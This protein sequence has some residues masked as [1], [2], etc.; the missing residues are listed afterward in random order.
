VKGLAIAMLVVASLSGCTQDVDPV[1]PNPAESP[2]PPAQSTPPTSSPAE[3][4]SPSSLLEGAPEALAR[5]Y[6]AF[7][8]GVS[9]QIGVARADGSDLR[10]LTDNEFPINPAWSP[11][12]DW[13][14]YRVEAVDNVFDASRYG[15][16]AVRPDGTDDTSLSSVSGVLGGAPA[17]SPDGSRLAFMGR[18][19][20]ER[21]VGI[22]VIN[23]DGSEPQRLTPTTFEAQYPAWSPDGAW[24]VYT[25]VQSFQFVIHK[26]RVDGTDDVQLTDGPE[27][28]WPMWS[29]DGRTIAFSGADE[30]ALMDSDG[31]DRRSLGL[32]DFLDA[33]VPGTWT[34][35]GWLSF[36]CRPDPPQIDLCVTWPDDLVVHRILAGFDA[37][38]PSFAPIDWHP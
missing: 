16:W 29:P 23:A 32:P 33:G 2:P 30:I 24:I 9:E 17:W 37:G 20:D 36:A 7:S 5:R 4:A 3:T 18:T 21:R 27:D 31:G 22:Y 26:M 25:V 19:S 34:S 38:F 10:V 14:A 11:L 13:I 28:N 35:D 1:T 6:L 8:H 12:G 15:I